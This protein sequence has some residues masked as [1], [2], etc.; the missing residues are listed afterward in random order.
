M[1][2]Q[3]YVAFGVGL[4]CFILLYLAFKLDDKHWF[5]Q[6]MMIGI[7]IHLGLLIPSTFVTLNEDCYPV[8]NTSTVAGATTTYTYG[9]YCNTKDITTPNSFFTGYMWIIRVFWIYVVIFGLKV[10]VTKWMERKK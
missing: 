1:T 8:V 9:E 5:L 6:I 7:V 4:V 3:L 10:A 2:T